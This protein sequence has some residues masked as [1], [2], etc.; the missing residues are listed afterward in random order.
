M[1]VIGHRGAA[2][3]A[4]ENTIAG[5]KAAMKVGVDAVEFDIRVSK[6]KKLFLCH[7]ASL[8][9]TYNVDKKVSE[10]TSSELKK[11]SDS[12]GHRIPT[13]EEA[14]EACGKTTAIIEAKSGN[15]AEPLSKVLHKHPHKKIHSVISFNH[16]EL[17][18]FQK[19]LPEIPL[20]VLE[21][22]N[23]FDAINAARLYGFQGI[24]VN[25]W[26]LNPLAYAL[27]WRHKLEIIVFTVNNV[28]IAKFL[29]LLYPGIA[30]TTNDPH[31]MQ[32]FRTHKG[33][34]K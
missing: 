33:A 31:V 17:N 20:Y 3:I 16:Q 29:R 25:F 27:A 7:D 15:W 10:L 1:N 19:L 6:D 4:P 21:H 22:R 28:W 12:E 13:L 34:K 14:L 9:R 32:Q 30:I 26:T 2:N 8:L 23:A 5:I 24:D 11:I 18:K